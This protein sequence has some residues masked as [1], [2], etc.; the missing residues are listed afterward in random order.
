MT[1]PIVKGEK[2]F[3]IVEAGI[4][5]RLYHQEAVLTAVLSA[6]EIAHRHSVSVI[7]TKT[8]RAR[9]KG[10][11]CDGVSGDRRG[12]FLDSAVDFGGQ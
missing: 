8:G 3:L 11:A 6:R 4:V 5:A 1:I 2:K 12:A 9:D 10:V 7:P